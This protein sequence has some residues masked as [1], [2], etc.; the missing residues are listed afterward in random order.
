MIFEDLYNFNYFEN[1]LYD[2]FCM[3]SCVKNVLDFWGYKNSFSFLNATLMLELHESK[4]SNMGFD[5]LYDLSYHS[6]LHFCSENIVDEWKDCSE[7]ENVL[8]ENMLALAKGVIPIVQVDSYYLP[9]L[10]YYKKSHGAHSIILCGSDNYSNIYVVDWMKPWFFKGKISRRE[11]LQ[12]RE[13]NNEYDNGPFS[14]YPISNKWIGIRNI[15]WDM[16]LYNA[17]SITIKESILNFYEKNS[18]DKVFSGLN[19]LK[20]LY[21]RM[22]TNEDDIGMFCQYIYDKLYFYYKKHLLLLNY[23]KSIQN[24]N[25]KYV[26]KICTEYLENLVLKYDI[27]FR[28]LLKTRF[29]KSQKNFDILCKKFQEIVICEKNFFE[30]IDEIYG[31]TSNEQK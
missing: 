23:L 13:S 3:Q 30:K 21:N 18:K 28:V 31:V 26:P 11:F 5:I 14:G 27:W 22:M 15:K 4:N 19:A 10:P 9:Y 25:I 16:P 2:A 24:V 8:C 17:L 29:S 7:T 20:W 1:D 12:A 6:V